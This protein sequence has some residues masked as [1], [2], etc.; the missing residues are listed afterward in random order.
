MYKR[1]ISVLAVLLL[2]IIFPRA[3]SAAQITA[4]EAYKA[5]LQSNMMFYSV[6][7]NKDYKLNEF[8][9][10]N[11]G[12][13]LEV[14]RFT[15]VDMDGDGLPEVVLD[16]DNTRFGVEV[17][18]YEGGRV[19]GFNMSYMPG[20]A[21]D[22]IYNGN[23]SFAAYNIQYYK[24]TSIEKGTYKKESLARIEYEFSANGDIVI[25]SYRI[26]ESKVTEDE[27]NSF[28]ESIGDHIRDN[29]VVWHDFTEADIALVFK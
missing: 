22:G 26:G 9:Y 13:P 29:E 4:M 25:T 5:V 14:Y 15:V 3:V 8:D 27:F 17:L 2:I 16:F 1:S 7:D 12:D 10:M 19:Y 6:D 18:H 21:K 20:L 24:I 23:A 11:D 28:V